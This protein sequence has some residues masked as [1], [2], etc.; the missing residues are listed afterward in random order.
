MGKVIVL[1][2][3]RTGSRAKQSAY[4]QIALSEAGP[5]PARRS[6]HPARRDRAADDRR[7]R[8]RPSLARRKHKR[9]DPT[10]LPRLEAL[11]RGDDRRRGRRRISR[12]R[13]R[14]P[15]RSPQLSPVPQSSREEDVERA[16]TGRADIHGVPLRRERLYYD[17]GRMRRRAKAPSSAAC[18]AMACR[19]PAGARHGHRG[20][21]ASAA[22]RVLAEALSAAFVEEL[23]AD[24]TLVRDGSLLRLPDAHDS[25][26]R[27]D[28]QRLVGPHQ[29][30]A[31]RDPLS[32][33]DLKQ[34]ADGLGVE[35][36][37]A[38]RA[39]ARA[40]ARAHGRR[41]S[42]RICTS[43]PKSSIACSAGRS[44]HCRDGSD[45]T[46]AAFRDSFR[47]SRKYAIPLLEYFDREGRHGQ[48]RRGATAEERS[49]SHGT[50]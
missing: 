10:L 20:A 42:R 48:D 38:H 46:P 25:D 30:S 2:T 34:I 24:R 33:P 27:P 15:C 7:R 43:W 22:R 13:R 47:T 4:C 14:S 37:K 50:A 23:E 31:R 26:C 6:L 1:R 35:S 17:R 41:A 49:R 16:S 44:R 11:H 9:S 8:R 28:D 45:L 5:G 3:A 32:P 40:G 18:S 39:A 29:A 36:A 12:E 21:R 19:P